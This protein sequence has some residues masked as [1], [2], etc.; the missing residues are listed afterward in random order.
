MTHKLINNIVNADTGAT[1]LP[2][3]DIGYRTD[4]K[5]HLK[6]EILEGLASLVD[7]SLLVGPTEDADGN[8][9]GKITQSAAESQE[10]DVKSSIESFADVITESV[11][12]FCEQFM[13]AHFAGHVEQ[14]HFSNIPDSATVIAMLSD[15][16]ETF[17][18]TSQI[19]EDIESGGL[20]Y[21]TRP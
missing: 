15:N 4:I 14:F 13:L 8:P 6:D 5:Q 3:L 17:K 2:T 10:N 1:P 9:T 7:L 12:N 11:F 18:A 20:D 19:L 16:L 21:D